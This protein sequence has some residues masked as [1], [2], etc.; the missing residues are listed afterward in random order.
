MGDLPRRSRL[1]GAAAALGVAALLAGCG[2]SSS[3]TSSIAVGNESNNSVPSTPTTPASGNGQTP[4][5]GPLSK[6]PTVTPPTGPA[7]TSLVTKDL[8]AGTGRAAKAGDSVTVNYVGV[9]YNNGKEFD[10]SWKRNQPLSFPLGQ[11]QVIPG[12]DQGVVGMKVGGR[13]E[14]II[15]AKLAYGPQGQPPTIPP[16]SP[17]VFVVDMLGIQ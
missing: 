2:S 1:G 17:L 10:A 15:P 5:S 6:Q 7:P 16:N 11:G 4:T 3:S 14:L 9:L 8:I 13:R 12:W